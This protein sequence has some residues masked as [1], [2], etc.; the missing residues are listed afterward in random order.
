MKDLLVGTDQDTLVS[1]PLFCKITGLSMNE[2]EYG[3][4]N[5]KLKPEY[6]TRDFIN[7]FY[8]DQIAIFTSHKANQA[9]EFETMNNHFEISNF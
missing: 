1:I 5:V 4:Y 2:I 3:V 7:H 9:S 8:D 6:N